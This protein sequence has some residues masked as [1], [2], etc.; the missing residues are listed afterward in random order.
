MAEQATD[1]QSVYQEVDQLKSIQPRSSDLICLP[2]VKVGDNLSVPIEAMILVWQQIVQENKVDP[3]FYDGCVK[4]LKEFLDYIYNPNNYVVLVVW[5]NS[6]IYH[7]AWINKFYQG[8]GF[9]HHCALG[10]YN[11]KTWPLL[12]KYWASMKDDYCKPII[13]T[14]LGV[15]P[16]S[17]TKACKLLK[18]IGWT[19]LGE[20]PGICY[21]YKKDINE[22]GIIS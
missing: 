18:V 5:K 9:V 3:L 21:N 13:Y 14:V 7:I 17:N 22:S 19:I 20:I 12:K 10:N 16:A 1:Y 15:T 2:V 8:H 4:N 11:R 6:H